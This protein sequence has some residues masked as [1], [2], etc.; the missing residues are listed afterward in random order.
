MPTRNVTC[1]TGLRGVVRNLKG[2]EAN[3]LADKATARRLLTFD[4][5]LEACW[6][7]TAEGGQLT[8]RYMHDGKVQ[9]G[10]VLLGDRF[11]VLLAIRIATLGPEY[12]FPHKCEGCS[13]SFEW[14][15]D[16]EKDLRRQPYS[17]A[18]IEAYRHDQAITD[19]LPDGKTFTFRI[20]NGE[21]EREAAKRAQKKRDELV[22]VA[23]S[24]RIVSIDGVGEDK[25]SIRA[26]L[27]EIDMPDVYEIGE[28][29]DKHEGGIVT[30]IEIECEH[31]GHE[32]LVRLP[33][34]GD[35]WISREKRR[36]RAVGED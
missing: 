22:T 19:K 4:K 12:S 25:Q 11:E 2:A 26:Y 34:V 21:T 28:T 14:E 15:L 9:W 20:A 36:K 13:E 8:D 10:R 17:A 6:I 16:L 32:N 31:C 7:E 1:P 27:E 29:I 24:E 35:F 3:M 30:D 18:S 33:F 5:I 23:I